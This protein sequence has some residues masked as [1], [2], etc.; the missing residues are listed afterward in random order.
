MS[1][2]ESIP[3][4]ETKTSRLAEDRVVGTGSEKFASGC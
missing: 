2:G 3:F 4:P 1:P